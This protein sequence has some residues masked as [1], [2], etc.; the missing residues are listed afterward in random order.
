MFLFRITHCHYPLVFLL[1]GLKVLKLVLVLRR[2]FRQIFA[3][4]D[5]GVQWS[6]LGVSLGLDGLSLAFGWT[7]CGPMVQSW[8]GS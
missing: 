8:S 1:E 2:E 4:L 7:P 5:L 3:C 6:S